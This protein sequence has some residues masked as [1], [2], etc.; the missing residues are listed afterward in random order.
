MKP[1]ITV[2]GRV[3]ESVGRAIS[4]RPSRRAP[5]LRFQAAFLDYSTFAIYPACF[6]DGR[7]APYHVLE[8][9][10]DH[11][12]VDRTVDGRVVATKASL[13]EGFVRN[14]FFYT[15]TAAARAV[16][17]WSGPPEFPE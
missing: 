6:A 7:L 14:G 1:I 12:V 17:H 8:G 2:K 4:T 5:V 16:A 11:L 15:R 13:I 3:K 10:P 9:L